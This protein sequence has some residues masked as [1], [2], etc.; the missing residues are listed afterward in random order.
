VRPRRVAPAAVA[1]GVG[2]VG[3][4][5]VGGRDRD[6]AGALPAPPRVRLRVARDLVALP[7]RRAVV[8]QDLAQG[9]RVL[10]VARRV[11]VA[12]PARPA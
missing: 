11:Q 9:R 5:Q 3:R 2:V 8:V 10:P 12:V 4:A 6:G 7:A 1:A